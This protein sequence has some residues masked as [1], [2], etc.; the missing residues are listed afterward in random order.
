[1]AIIDHSRGTEFIARSMTKAGGD[2]IRK[3]I[4]GGML[5]EETKE[6]IVSLIETRVRR[7]RRSC[8]QRTLQ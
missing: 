5:P 7:Q 6:E 3:A 2:N 4:T 8:A 1:M